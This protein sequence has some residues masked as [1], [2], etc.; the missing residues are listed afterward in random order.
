MNTKRNGAETQEY[1]NRLPSLRPNDKYSSASGT[2]HK[3]RLRMYIDGIGAQTLAEMPLPE[4]EWLVDKLLCTES[5]CVLASAPKAGKSYLALQLGAA[6]STGKPF[7]GYETRK[8]GV[9]YLALEDRFK[10]VQNR[11]WAIAD[12][13]TDDFE[14]ETKILELGNG[15]IDELDEY[16]ARKPDTKLF[17][18]DTL[19]VVRGEGN[20]CHYSSDYGDIRKLKAFSDEHK[21]CLLVLTH[22]RKMFSKADV[23]T[24]IT[25]TNGI[26]GASDQMMVLRKKKRTA[27]ESILD[28]TGRDVPDTRLKLRRNSNGLWE[29][30]ESFTDEELTA[31]EVP[32]CVKTVTSY[33]LNDAKQWSGTA[34]ELLDKLGLDNVTP[35]VLGKFL[36]QHAD[37]M[38]E[39]G[40]QFLYKRASTARSVTLTPVMEIDPADTGS[41]DIDALRPS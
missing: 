17:I 41:V 18:I 3:S 11:L 39:H 5:L 25:G 32:D 6:V 2:D 4:P 12:E 14:I 7:F 37:W 40:V 33:I 15:L 8:A 27:P 9:L 24:N 26:S 30:I 21:V 34:S 29:L 13:L 31:S 19:Q 22:L 20:D 23:F 10:R 16:I 38:R 36:A 28:I 1:L 35:S